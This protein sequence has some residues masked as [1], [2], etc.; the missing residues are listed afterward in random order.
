MEA[1]V[2]ILDAD[3]YESII[4]LWMRAGLPY[5]P[6][7]RDKR[8]SMM[9]QMKRDPELFLGAFRENRLVGTVI[10][11]YDGRKGWVNRLAVDPRERRKGVAHTLVVRIEEALRKRGARVLAALV[12]TDNSESIALFQKCGF[13]VHQ[14]I[15]Y[16]TKRDSDQA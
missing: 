10:G 11:T 12:E 13:T 5:R 1:E 3:D 8:A 14:N 16:L 2:R 7:G 9:E 15:L 6:T 4:A